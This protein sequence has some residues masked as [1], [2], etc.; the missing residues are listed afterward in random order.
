MSGHNA[1]LVR[2]LHT[3]CRNPFGTTPNLQN[4]RRAASPAAPWAKAEQVARLL[5]PHTI[6]REFVDSPMR[7]SS[8]A[9]EI[10]LDEDD[11]SDDH[12]SIEIVWT[13][14]KI[15][16]KQQHSRV[17]KTLQLG[18]ELYLGYYLLKNSFPTSKLRTAFGGDAL[19][20]A[21]HRLDYQDIVQRLLDA[22]DQNCE[23]LATVLHARVS[24]FRA[25]AKAVSD[26]TVLPNF[27]LR[28][29]SEQ[30]VSFLTAGMRYIY[31]LSPGPIDPKMLMRGDDVVANDRPYMALGVHEVLTQAFF[32]GTPSVASKYVG[33][34]PVSADGRKQCPAAMIALG[35]TVIHCSLNEH[36]TGRHI[37]SQFEGN[38]LQEAYDTHMLVLDKASA[39][40]PNLLADIYDAVAGGSRLGSVASQPMAREA[41]AMLGLP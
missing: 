7:F 24:T 30:R 28:S 8:E 15:G 16:L 1:L 36:R 5:P 33:Q 29:N 25:K 40:N 3:R 37:S 17:E 4:L 13:D 12:S 19:L 9:I 6:K 2:L 34:F 26:M 22:D 39:A 20:N 10:S 14:R 21:A 31:P 18:I 38:T 11:K 23:N 32:K 41:L 27:D 35:C